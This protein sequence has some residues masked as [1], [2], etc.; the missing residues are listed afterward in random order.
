MDI[1]LESF[2][3]AKLLI[4]TSHDQVG[5]DRTAKQIIE[6]LQGNTDA[7]VVSDLA[8]TFSEHHSRMPWK[9]YCGF[10][11]YRVVYKPQQA[12]TKA[13]AIIASS[14]S[15]FHFYWSRLPNFMIL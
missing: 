13:S 2:G 6:Y 5:T 11:G 7:N 14:K 10:N 1:S 12:Y 3:H 15:V 9:T 4:W 8:F